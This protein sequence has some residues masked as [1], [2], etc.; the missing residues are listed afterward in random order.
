MT[1]FEGGTLNQFDVSEFL[2]ERDEQVF[3]DRVVELYDV[4][5][6]SPIEYQPEPCAS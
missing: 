4:T 2:K 5:P 6:R 3:M 1:D